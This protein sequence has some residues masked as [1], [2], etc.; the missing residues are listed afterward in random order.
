MLLSEILYE[1]EYTSSYK[2]EDISFSRITV[3]TARLEK[4]CVFVCMRGMRFDS[5]SMASLASLSGA[6]AVI[7]DHDGRV[8]LPDGFPL[9]RVQ[10]T[11]AILPYLISRSLGNAWQKSRLIAITGTNGKTSTL[12]LTDAILRRAGYSVGCVG[13]VDI[14]LN[15]APLPLRKEEEDAVRTMT[16]PDPTVLFPI[17]CRMAEA[18]ADYIIME[19]SSHA[20]A[21]KK[22]LPLTFELGLFTNLSPEHL[23][24]H[25]NMEDYLRA[26]AL[27]FP[28]C[29][30][31][32]LNGDSPYSYEIMRRTG[33]KSLLVGSEPTHD[34]YSHSV[35]SHGARGTDFTLRYQKEEMPIALSLSGTYNVENARMAAA[36]ALT[37]GIERRYVTEALASFEGIPGRLE[38]LTP[39]ELPFAVF[40]DYAHTEAAL[41]KVLSTVR[42]F[43]LPHER[44]ILLFGCGGE[45]DRT[46][47][48]PMG[49][50][51][52]SYADEIIVTSDNPRKENPHEI[53]SDIL[54]GMPNKKKRR[55]TVNRA[56]AIR[57]A[58]LRA[59]AGDIILLCGK[60]HEKY[61]ITSDG[62]HPFD[63][64]ALVAEAL[65]ER[66]K[67]QKNK[68]SDVT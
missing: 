4:N 7:A 66:Q 44:I 51:A 2:A 47:R 59:K 64:R 65:A 9:F 1:N 43:R 22:L 15:G 38:R 19:A 32:I 55:V 20:L 30:R 24:Y 8:E 26:K 5:H 58:V 45:R 37:L 35:L 63:E 33:V 17:L 28:L 18:G 56:R 68:E 21:Q 42:S 31:A 46:K 27:L 3:N 34:F 52:E 53:I 10:D 23:D 41:K 49:T 14:L 62:V 6:C 29:R 16:T 36:A 61:E 13:T 60:G 50:V 40:I 39:P 11:H 54:R 25:A 57:E 48:A 67:N 12:Y